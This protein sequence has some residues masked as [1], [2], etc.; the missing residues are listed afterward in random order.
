MCTLG[1]FQ[2]FLFWKKRP[3]SVIVNEPDQCF[4][5]TNRISSLVAITISISLLPPSSG[6]GNLIPSRTKASPQTALVSFINRN[7][8]N[9]PDT[10]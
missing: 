9:L 10:T 3:S 4:C 2:F 8:A 7:S 5:S 6:S 1:R